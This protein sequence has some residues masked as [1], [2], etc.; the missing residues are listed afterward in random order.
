LSAKNNPAWNSAADH[1]RA[2]SVHL[3]IV[4][5]LVVMVFVAFLR[6]WLL[7]DLVALSALR[8]LLVTG[9]LGTD[10]T[11]EVFSNSARIVIG[12]MEKTGT[13]EAIEGIIGSRSTFVGKTLR[14]LNLRQHYGLLI[15]AVH[16][17]GE[18]LRENF[19]DVRLA[20]GR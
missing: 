17:Q 14:E 10:E 16:R 15:L 2:H 18:N 9:I 7:P 13:L 5:A 12:C 4:F 3:I 6:E 11:L 20:F 1:E 8:L 19:E